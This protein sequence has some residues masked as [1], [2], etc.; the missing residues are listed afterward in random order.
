[1]PDTPIR[2]ATRGSPLALAQADEVAAG[3]RSA[4]GLPE[5]M[6]EILVIHT[7]GD[8]IQDRPLADAGGKGLFTKEIEAALLDGRADLAVHSAKD[9]PTV[10]PDGLVLSAFLKREDVRD[11]FL[12]RIA[13]SLEA[14]PR[15]TVVGTASLRRQ[16]LV[17]RARPDLTVVTLRGNVQTRL[18]KLDD[19]EY[20]AIILASAGLK[21]LELSERIT[22]LLDVTVSLPAVG[23]GAVGIEC[24]SDDAEIN[25]LLA[26]LNHE[27]T[28]LRVK[29]ER[30]MNRRLEGGCQVPIGGYAELDHGVIVLHGLVGRPDGTQLVTGSISGR[31]EDADELGRVLAEDLLSRGAGAILREV[32]GNA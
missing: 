30:A 28:A 24:R 18:R 11:A 4:H 3:L 26:P 7:S 16:A 22:E 31:P 20:D 8:R 23:Q 5:T 25:A 1:M 15:G 29:A 17:R 32:Y 13:P 12:S 2:I 10:L 27:P 6:T 21:R 14:L 19:G 9:M